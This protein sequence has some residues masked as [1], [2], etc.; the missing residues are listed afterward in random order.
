[1]EHLFYFTK[2]LHAYAGKILY[3]NLLGM[4]LISFLD[5]MGIFLLLPLLDISGIMNMK[6]GWISHLGIFE[7][8][9]EIPKPLA[10]L[11][12]V[13]MYVIL[14][15]G[16]SLIQRNL[17]LRD[18]KIHTGF[19]N[20]VRLETYNALL[21]ANWDFF[22]KKRK[23]D[24]INSLTGELG[25]VT[26]GT[27]IFLQF[28]TSI[29]FTLIQIG[30]ALFL[31]AKLTIF[32][33]ICG[34][35]VSF[36][37]RT[38]IK[39]SRMLGNQSLEL[40]RS[41]IGGITDHFNGI[42]DIKSNML[43][44]SRRTWL[45]NWSQRFSQERFEQTKL[46]ANSELYY[47]ISSSLIIGFFIYASN[48]FFQ[49]QGQQLMLIILIFFRL[50]PRFQGVQTNLEQISAAIPAFKSLKELQ[51][52]CME[53]REIKGSSDYNHEKPIRIEE[54][55]E[56]R[57]VSFRYNRNEQLYALQDINLRIPSKQMTA[58]IGRSGAGKSTLI[59][60]LMGLLK[61]E[62][63][64]V[65]VDGVPLTEANLL[66]LRKSISY[67]PQ[68]PFLFNG[69]IR[70][71]ML[72]IDPSAT[73]EQLW[74]SLEFAASA[75]FVSKLPQGLDTLIGDRGIRLSGGE[76]QRLVLARAIL[77]KP[78]ILILDEATSAL[79]SENEAKIQEA[80]ER[81]QGK[82]TIIV[83]AHRLSTIRN[84]DQVIVLD[85]GRI[86]QSGGYTQ[87]TGEKEGL[88]ASL[89]GNQMQET[90]KSSVTYLGSVA[91]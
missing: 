9:N 8:F 90:N 77:R 1:M 38:F 34:L 27:Y 89:L 33:L 50:W 75:E 58:I 80:L 5:G 42:K 25:H 69:S 86:I 44:E 59:D 13:G 40:G 43:E 19:I 11:L 55:L 61:P 31:S 52:E 7:I 37:S 41:Y 18:I 23:S 48:M 54:Y 47:K 10:L 26:S 72:M 57:D 39:R 30:I 88:F 74:E 14:I 84:A 16:Q 83:I 71:N 68:D 4:V 36:F 65:L 35:A 60:I 6:M 91:T 17:N 73:E 85:K 56:C 24:L 79:D 28:L 53:A 45:I 29:V 87:L 78:S 20:H 70:D 66:A 12:I 2:Q 76:R 3:V 46:R 49:T 51:N 32:V 67:V 63:G 64:Q 21:Q 81:L 62:R 15:S 22:I 82:L